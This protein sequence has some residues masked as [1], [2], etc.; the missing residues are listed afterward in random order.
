MVFV[1]ALAWSEENQMINDCFLQR[2]IHR[3]RWIAYFMKM[4]Y[5]SNKFQACV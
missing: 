5:F 1:E 4:L 2:A 3:E